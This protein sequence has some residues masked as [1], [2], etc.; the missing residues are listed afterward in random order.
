MSHLSSLQAQYETFNTP[1]RHHDTQHSYNQNNDTQ[2][3]NKLFIL[4]VIM[5]SVVAIL[6]SLLKSSRHALV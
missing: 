2:H 5:L 4:K 1:E 3:N 6:E